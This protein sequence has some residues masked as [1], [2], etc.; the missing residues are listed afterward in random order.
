[1]RRVL[2]AAVIAT[3]LS[4]LTTPTA[5]YGHGYHTRSGSATSYCDR[6]LTAS[7]QDTRPGIVASNDL[8][9]E[10]WVE[11]IS[12]RRVLGRRYWQVQ[13]TGGPGFVLDF[14]SASCSW[15]Q[16]WGRRNVRYRTVPQHH[17]YRGRPDGGWVWSPR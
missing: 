13:D 8:P 17:L 6:G 14:W 2:A 3:A 7:G 12:P 16:D 9:L 11:L 1:M 10:S 5:A 4:A 15:A